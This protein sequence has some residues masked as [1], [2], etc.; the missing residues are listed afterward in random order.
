MVKTGEVGLN[1]GRVERDEGRMRYSIKKQPNLSRVYLAERR[2]ELLRLNLAEL[3]DRL[4]KVLPGYPNVA[5]AYL[6]GSALDFVRPDSDIDLALIL[7]K[8]PENFPDDP[9]DFDLE[10][11]LRSFGPHRFQV[12]V[13]REE[14]NNFAFRVLTKGELI[15]VA[16][17]VRLTN[18]LEGVARVHE[19]HEPFMRT[20]HVA[21][22]RGFFYGSGE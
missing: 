12:T 6:F 17:P 5:G 14:E 13:L 20:Y 3:K 2:G 21:R 9:T 22:G 7:A 1:G 15:Y 4:L 11:D 19:D 10:N 16:D 8:E 18:F